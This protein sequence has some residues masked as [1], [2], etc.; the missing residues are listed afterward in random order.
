MV[1]PPAAGKYGHWTN[2]HNPKDPEAWLNGAAE[3]AGSWWP[4]WSKWLAKKSGEKVPARVPG[5]GKLEV[6]EDAPGA[7][8]KVMAHD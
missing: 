4:T 2:T 7:Y 5:D 1:N 8:V 6:I 3:H